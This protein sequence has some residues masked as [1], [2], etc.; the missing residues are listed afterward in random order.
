MDDLLKS[1]SKTG[2]AKR[3][4]KELESMLAK[5]RFHL[6]KWCSNSREILQE[7]PVE[8][9]A[10]TV[11][12]LDLQ[13][14]DLPMDSALGVHWNVEKDT[15]VL[16]VDGKK[17]PNN[18]RG[19]LSSI[20]TIYDPLG[21]ASPLLLPAREINQELCRLKVDWNSELPRKL[22][23]GWKKWKEDLVNLRSH[24]MPRCLKPKGFG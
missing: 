4:S 22:S 10:P 14:E 2:E 15:I 20:A 24:E 1:F 8:G 9:R 13:S 18:Q 7:F 17:E 12:N 6:T 5:A 3:V 19:V 16:V 21:F 11:K 23:V